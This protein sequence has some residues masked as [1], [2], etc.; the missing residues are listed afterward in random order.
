[1]CMY[2]KIITAL[3]CV[4]LNLVIWHHAICITLQIVFAFNIAVFKL[5][6]GE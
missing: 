1:M 3:F 2:S 4:F 6:Y 5:I